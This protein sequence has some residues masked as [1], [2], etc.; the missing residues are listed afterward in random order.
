ML[1][2][3]SFKTNYFKI[4]NSKTTSFQI[5][6]AVCANSGVAQAH[7]YMLWKGDLLQFPSKLF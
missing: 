5:L 7:T 4:N 6:Q 3:K 2:L 1:V